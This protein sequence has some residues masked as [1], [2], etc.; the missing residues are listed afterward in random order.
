[1][2]DHLREAWGQDLD[3]HFSEGEWDRVLDRMHTSSPCARHGLIQFK[4][5]HR[6]HIT[7]SKLA[8]IYP[9]ANPACSRCKHSPCTLAHM[10][11]LCP[12]LETFWRE[13]FKFFNEIA[14]LSIDPNPLM[15]IFGVRPDDI[16]LSNNVYSVIAVTTLLA[17]WLILLKW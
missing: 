4:V 10:F 2:L 13:I 1:M 14:G 6:L 12:V 8:R 17:R 15:A 3:M 11:W 7:N 9:D 5:L 16:A